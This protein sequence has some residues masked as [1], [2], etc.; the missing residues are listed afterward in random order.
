MTKKRQ[1]RP[2]NRDESRERIL[3]AA[4]REFAAKG[5]DGARVDAIAAAARLNKQLLYH[6]FGS[7]DGLFTEVLERAYRGIREAEAAVPLDGLRADE[8]ILRLV[9]FT[10]GYYLAHPDFIRLLNS[11]NQLE[12]RHLKRSPNTPA[13]NRGHRNLLA[14]LIRQGRREGSLR[15]DLEATQL[16][17]N[18][19]A[20]AFFY[21]MN[22]HT[23][24]VVFDR[25]LESRARL[26][27]R[28]VVMKDVIRRWIQPART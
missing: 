18:V 22:R 2:R 11:E 27:E 10:W 16:S 1:P 26:A 24:S 12:A 7:K 28:L 6:Y 14:R 8:A 5:F 19:A 4:G 25:N 23:L 13:I 21:L 15:G 17:I 9:E 20:L 3:R